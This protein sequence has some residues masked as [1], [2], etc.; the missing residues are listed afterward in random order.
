MTLK[1]INYNCY[2][3]NSFIELVDNAQ[4]LLD[5]IDNYSTTIDERKIFAT[6][7]YHVNFSI[8]KD[9]DNDAIK[10]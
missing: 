1:K 5:N 4:N 10:Y 8:P 2:W 6:K 7:D 3:C 9:Q